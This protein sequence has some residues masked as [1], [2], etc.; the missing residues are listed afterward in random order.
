VKVAKLAWPRVCS[1]FWFCAVTW[2]CQLGPLHAITPNDDR[3]RATQEPAIQ[4]ICCGI[5]YNLI[6]SHSFSSLPSVSVCHSVHP[7]VQCGS[8]TRS[9]GGP[10][11]RIMTQ[12]LLPALRLVQLT[13]ADFTWQ[14]A[15]IMPFLYAKEQRFNRSLI[16]LITPH[17]PRILHVHGRFKLVIDSLRRSPCFNCIATYWLL[18]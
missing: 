6:T 14:V 18:H 7:L 11:P 9:F 2:A 17:A 1:G 16:T 3:D 15:V 8:S 10:S 13:G 5:L 12:T 4:Y